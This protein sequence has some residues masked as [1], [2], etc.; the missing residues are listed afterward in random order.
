M[1]KIY[2]NIYSTVTYHNRF[3]NRQC[4]FILTAFANYLHSFIKKIFTHQAGRI[5]IRLEKFDLLK[6][7]EGYNL[8]W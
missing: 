4:T 6:L 3:F 2:E 7:Q 8:F 5:L 1:F